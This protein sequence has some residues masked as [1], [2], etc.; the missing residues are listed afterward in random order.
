M[1][2][3]KNSIILILCALLLL[4]VKPAYSQETGDPPP[5]ETNEISEEELDFYDSLSFDELLN[6]KVVSASHK[7][8][9]VGEAPANIHVISGEEL[10]NRGYRTLYDLVHDLPGTTWTR[11]FGYGNNGTPVIRGIF[12]SKRLKLMLNGMTID[13]KNGDGTRW[14]DRFPIEGIDRVEFIIGPYASLYGRNTFSG[15]MNVI[16][17]SGEEINGVQANFLYGEYHRLQGTALYGQKLGAFDLYLSFFKNYSKDGIDWAEEYPEYYSI[18]Y[19]EAQSGQT[20][21]G[22]VSEDFIGPWDM[23]ELYF[24]GKHDSGIQFDIQVNRADNPKV[25]NVMTPVIYTS[26]KEALAY[27]NLVNA[28]LLYDLRVGSRFSTTT[29]VEFQDYRYRGTNYYINA[30]VGSKWYALKSWS[31]LLD[32]KMRYKLFDWNEIYLGIAGEYVREYDVLFGYR[33]EEPSWGASEVK[34]KK[35]LNI[36]LQDEMVFFKRLYFVGGLMYETSNMYDQVFIPRGSV[37][38]KF[39][40]ST[41]VKFLYGAGFFPPDPAVGVDQWYSGGPAGTKGKRSGIRPEY[42]HSFDLNLIHNFSKNLRLNT[43]LFY[44][45]VIDRIQQVADSSLPAPYGF[46]WSNTGSTESRGAD[47]SI[48]GSFFDV[49]KIFVSY[50]YVHGSYDSVATDGTVTTYNHL[51]V[52]AKHHLKAGLNILLIGRRFNLYIHDLFMG[53]RYTFD[54]AG[55]QF[56]TPG[57]TMDGYNLIDINLSTTPELL[58]DFYFSVGVKNL[59]DTKGYDVYHLHSSYVIFPP[60]QR[61]TW[62]V[63]TG[64]KYTF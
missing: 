50:S 41:I 8:Q 15:V 53:N 47:V 28:R 20:I 37:M 12:D 11:A 31:V 55:F 36:T 61:R 14:C 4:A 52:S 25:G 18:E 38:F 43:S 51:P 23:W 22:V 33:E 17:K 48:D 19:R 42:M 2:F 39:T 13:P 56:A 24:K 58:K 30:A 21:R 29:T 34:G 6:L 16:T 46:T 35:I 59:L 49:V 10:R 60:I 9:P 40:E 62:S 45:K 63:Q 44:I 54:E 32:E 27:T 5:A 7:E 3:F 26:P 1:K 57:Y 64:Y